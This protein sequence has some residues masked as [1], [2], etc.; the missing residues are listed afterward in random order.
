[1]RFGLAEPSLYRLLFMNADEVPPSAQVR[2]APDDAGLEAL[3]ALVEA[4]KREG[5]LD[6]KAD[7]YE[8]AIAYWATC[9]G[10]VS[11]YLA[12]ESAARFTPRAYRA[13]AKRALGQLVGSR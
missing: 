7:A 1:M 2:D 4:C 6:P 8:L 5:S 13:L 11:L 9:H 3:V 12:G 10:L